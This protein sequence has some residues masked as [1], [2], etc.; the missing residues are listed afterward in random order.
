MQCKMKNELKPIKRSIIRLAEPDYSMKKK[1]Q[2][3]SKPQVG[4]GIFTAI[5]S[6]VLPALIS[7]ITKK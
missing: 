3:L 6:F 1:R 7:L 5:A 2:I 4:K